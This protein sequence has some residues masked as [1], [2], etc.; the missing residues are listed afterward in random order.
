MLL[1]GQRGSRSSRLARR[2]A[3]SSATEH[4]IGQIRRTQTATP[5]AGPVHPPGSATANN[6][7]TTDRTSDMA[8]HPTDGETVGAEITAVIAHID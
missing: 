2:A 1:G 6:Y 5:T 4:R 8:P 7:G 3:R